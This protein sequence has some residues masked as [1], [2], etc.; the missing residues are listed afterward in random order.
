[1]SRA[2][3]NQVSFFPLY[4]Y[5][6]LTNHINRL[7]MKINVRQVIVKFFIILY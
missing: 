6:K 7:N 4:R 5:L 1:M 3:I 2:K